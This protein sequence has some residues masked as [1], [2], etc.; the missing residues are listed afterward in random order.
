[1]PDNS[2]LDFS[3][4]RD[5]YE[6]D[7]AGMLELYDLMLKNGASHLDK[8]DAAVHERDLEGVRKAA[9][10]LKGSSG[11]IGAGTLSRI[12]AQ[13]EDAARDAQW[14]RATDAAAGL[15]PEF[16]RVR[17]AVEQFRAGSG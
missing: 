4:L 2:A 5:V 11:N 17:Q 12:A 13:T 9:H 10:S 6:D 15:R 14:E 3:R 1:M 8:L 7:T 16:E